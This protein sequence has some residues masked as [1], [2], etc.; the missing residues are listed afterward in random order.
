MRSSSQ[1]SQ[2]RRKS[3]ETIVPNYAAALAGKPKLEE[4]GKAPS[5]KTRDIA[6]N[7]KSA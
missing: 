2:I 3:E 7:H 4:P 5:K 1:Q 6:N